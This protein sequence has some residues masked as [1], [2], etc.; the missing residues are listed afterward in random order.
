MYNCEWVSMSASSEH[1]FYSL[2]VDII[3]KFMSF[4]VCF[5][6]ILLLSLLESKRIYIFIGNHFKWAV[7]LCFS[8]CTQYRKKNQ[9]KMRIITLYGGEIYGS[10]MKMHSGLSALTLFWFQ[11]SEKERTGNEFYKLARKLKI[12]SKTQTHTHTHACSLK[13]CSIVRHQIR[14][15]RLWLFSIVVLIVSSTFLCPLLLISL[16]RSLPLVL[17][18]FVLLSLIRY[19]FQRGNQQ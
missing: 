14:F 12:T 16:S 13:K 5:S 8:L 18:G 9:L 4:F 2:T 1:S 11:C 10:I 19:T 15:Y 7:H 3:V 17:F 6:L